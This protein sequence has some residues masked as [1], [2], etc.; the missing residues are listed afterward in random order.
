MQFQMFVCHLNE[1]DFF[2]TKFVEY[3]NE[4]EFLNDGTYLKTSDNKD[5]G[6]ILYFDMM[7]IPKYEYKPIN[8]DID[9]YNEW[10]KVKIEEYG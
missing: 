2:E 1:C 3:E 8:M 10:K 9:E 6:V 4:D 7:G 5:K